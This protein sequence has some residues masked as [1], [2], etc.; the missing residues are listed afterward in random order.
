M[1]YFSVVLFFL[2][3]IVRKGHNNAQ[4]LTGHNKAPCEISAKMYIVFNLF[5]K[6]RTNKQM[7]ISHGSSEKGGAAKSDQ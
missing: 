4:P 2:D 6:Q 5:F 3:V 7:D 1:G